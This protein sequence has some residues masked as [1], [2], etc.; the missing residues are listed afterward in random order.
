MSYFEYILTGDLTNSLEER[1]T[2]ITDK[3]TKGTLP[4]SLIKYYDEEVSEDKKKR[5]F[6]LA[7][8]INMTNYIYSEYFKYCNMEISVYFKQ[9]IH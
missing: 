3:I 1:T 8:N 9:R 6:I 4:F 7:S 2:I 5:I